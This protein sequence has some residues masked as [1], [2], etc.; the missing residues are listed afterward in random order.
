MAAADRLRRAGYQVTVYDRYDRMGSCSPT[1]F[2]FKL[3][4][5]VI[6]RRTSHIEG[7]IDMQLNTNVGVDITFEELREKHDAI[8]IAT[9]VYKL[10]ELDDSTYGND[11][12]GNVQALGYLLHRIRRILG[13]MCPN[14]MMAP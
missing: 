1:V 4:K 13:M 5:Y 3:E 12:T 14:T 2:L 8:L 6:E 7:G 11:L 9:G 10:R